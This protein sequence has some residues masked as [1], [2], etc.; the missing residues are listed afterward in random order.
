MRRRWGGGAGGAGLG[1]AS[2]RA[3]AAAGGSRRPG[4]EP[5]RAARRPDRRG[6][7]GGARLALSR[8]PRGARGPRARGPAAAYSARRRA[9]SNGIKFR[10]APRPPPAPAR[11]AGRGHGRVVRAAPCRPPSCGGRGAPGVPTPRVPAWPAGTGKSSSARDRATDGEGPT[12]ADSP[13]APASSP[14]PGDR[15]SWPCTRRGPPARPPACPPSC[16]P[17]RLRVHGNRWR[18]WRPA[19]ARG[20]QPAPRPGRTACCARCTGA[21][22]EKRDEGPSGGRGARAHAGR[23]ARSGRPAGGGPHAA[24]G[25]ARP[26]SWIWTAHTSHASRHCGGRGQSRARG[27]SGCQGDAPCSPRSDLLGCLNVQELV[28]AFSG[29]TWPRHPVPCPP[30]PREPPWQ[31][32][33]RAE[34]RSRPPHGASDAGAPRQSGG[35]QPQPRGEAGGREPGAPAAAGAAAAP[36]GTRGRPPQAATP[37]GRGFP[38]DQPARLS[39][40][41]VRTSRAPAPPPGARARP[42]AP[43]PLPGGPPAAAAPRAEPPGAAAAASGRNGC[44]G[45][46]LQ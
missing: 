20:R 46:P 38:V 44:G 13:P 2:R 11:A 9:G 34:A 40:R 30:H 36:H 27:A 33:E 10:R 39:A 29:H 15:S 12:R 31:P 45:R 41:R 24:P 14:K 19:A 6:A 7:L 4:A 5:R 18:G 3:G 22:A 28:Q 25:A 42:R 37:C 21:E 35:G 17:C 8:R 32:A 23:P 26:D 43:A 1:P 16:G